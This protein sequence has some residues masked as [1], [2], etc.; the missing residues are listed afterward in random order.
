MLAYTY[1]LRTWEKD[2][3]F[4]V[5]VNLNYRKPYKS[6]GERAGVGGRRDPDWEGRDGE[7]RE[8]RE[9]EGDTE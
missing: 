8:V 4:K 6:E 3:K 5:E 9:D 1:S 7:K 2:R